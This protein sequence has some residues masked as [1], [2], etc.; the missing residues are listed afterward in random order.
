M[1]FRFAVGRQR[2]E[3]RLSVHHPEGEVQTQA[4]AEC[5]KGKAG[6]GGVERGHPRAVPPTPEI[7][8]LHT[9]GLAQQQATPQALCRL[10]FL[11]LNNY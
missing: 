6:R 7:K 5:D 9:A 3:L 1:D 2:E 4:R 8:G 10:M 11:L